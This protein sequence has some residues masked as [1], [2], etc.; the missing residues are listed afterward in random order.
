MKPCKSNKPGSGLWRKWQPSAERRLQG[1]EPAVYMLTLHYH[2][3]TS[4]LGWR[5]AT[6][7][8][9]SWSKIKLQIST[10]FLSK[11][12]QAALNRGMLMWLCLQWTGSYCGHVCSFGR[13]KLQGKWLS[14]SYKAKV[15]NKQ[16]P[17]R[18]WDLGFICS[19]EILRIYWESLSEAF[20][21][22]ERPCLDLLWRRW[23]IN[24]VLPI[25]AGGTEKD[26]CTLVLPSHLGD[27][28]TCCPSIL[29]DQ[30]P[31][32]CGEGDE[33]TRV[34]HWL[35]KLVGKAERFLENISTHPSSGTSFSDVMGP[36]GSWDP[37]GK[38]GGCSAEKGS[39]SFRDADTSIMPAS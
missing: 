21:K 20:R 8:L 30:Q 14:S 38:E 24:S 39:S 26:V 34:L 9:L 6:L 35:W 18:C 2:L 37:G 13:C 28:Y 15:L 36:R 32:C 4:H 25:I 27:K 29:A 23:N 17:C 3:S 16:Y 12:F 1:L 19:Y 5:A 31:N 11:Q 7:W 33:A 22:R 10:F